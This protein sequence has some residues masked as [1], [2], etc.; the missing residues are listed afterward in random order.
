MDAPGELRAAANERENIVITHREYGDETVVA[1]DFGAD[2]DLTLDVVG[3][4]AIVVAGARQFEFEVPARAE[5]SV[6][7]GVLRIVE[8]GTTGE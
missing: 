8:T 4:T 5:V 6:N 1:V 2:A 7:H 3:G